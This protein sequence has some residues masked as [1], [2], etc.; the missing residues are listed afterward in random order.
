MQTACSKRFEDVEAAALAMSEDVG[1]A[2]LRRL[3]RQF[4]SVKNSFL[5][6]EVKESFITCALPGDGEW[7]RGG[8]REGDSPGLTRSWPGVGGPGAGQGRSPP[9]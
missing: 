4:G 6:F 9:P 2:G 1:E 3:K 8:R 5:H 7:K